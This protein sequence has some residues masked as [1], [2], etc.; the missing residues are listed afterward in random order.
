[1]KRAKVTTIF[2]A[3]DRANAF[4]YRPIYVRPIEP[5]E[6]IRDT[7]KPHIELFPKG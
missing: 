7:Y 3:G 5:V 2:K 6:D 4:N 1:M